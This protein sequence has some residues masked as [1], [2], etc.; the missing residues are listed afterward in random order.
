MLVAAGSDHPLPAAP[1][2]GGPRP[3]PEATPGPLSALWLGTAA[4]AAALA[5]WFGAA[6]GPGRSADVT[7]GLLVLAAVVGVLPV[8][9]HAPPRLAVA[10]AF[11]AAAAFEVLAGDSTIELRLRPGA[12][13]AVQ[14]IVSEPLS[15]AE[16][17]ARGIDI[18]DP[19]NNTVFDFTVAMQI[20][21]PI[22]VPSVEVPIDPPPGTIFEFET[23]A[24]VSGGGSGPLIRRPFER[25]SQA[26]ARMPTARDRQN[27]PRLSSG[28]NPSSP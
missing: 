16:I 18:Q 21:P 12:T 5:G 8:G 24:Y 26:C 13:L 14:Q 11:A 25:S 28:S 27:R 1:P 23:T 3:S 22:I 17:I 19:L 20:G 15:S 4:A 2:E 9:R 7:V 6:A 10:P